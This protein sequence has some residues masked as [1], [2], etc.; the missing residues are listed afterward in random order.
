M[1][2]WEGLKVDKTK[3]VTNSNP[4]KTFFC[5]IY[6]KFGINLIKIEVDSARKR[7]IGLG[8][9]LKISRLKLKFE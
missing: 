5:I 8:L 3:I 2:S 7:F 6:A 4:T 9:E 1:D